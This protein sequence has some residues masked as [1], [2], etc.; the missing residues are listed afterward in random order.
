MSSATI[1]DLAK[2]IKAGEKVSV[3]D[4]RSDDEV[5]EK[6]SNP[7]SI[8]IPIAEFNDRI[9]EVPKGPVVVHCAIGKRAQRAGDALRAAGYAPV[10]NVT[11]RDAARKTVEEAKEL[12]Q[13]I[14]LPLVGVIAVAVMGSMMSSDSTTSADLAAAVAKGKKLSIVDVRSAGE[15]ASKASLPGAIAIPVGE[16]ESRISEVP[17]DGPVLVYCASGIRAGRAAGVLRSHGYGPVMSTVNCD[18]AKKI[19]D[20][21]EKLAKEGATAVSEEKT[22]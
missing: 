14:L 3:V 1:E 16:V 10:M 20:E 9:S 7:G 8:H 17:K 6:P 21:V 15:V 13:K 18:S 4:V 5:K 19:I 11:D 12:A 22:Q 2:A